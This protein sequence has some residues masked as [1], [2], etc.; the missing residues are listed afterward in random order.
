MIHPLPAWVAGFILLILLGL[1]VPW[2]GRAQQ[3]AGP[4]LSLPIACSPGQD[5]WLVNH[6]DL[7]PA[8]P[9]I[10]DFACGRLTYDGHNG[11]DLAIRDRAVMQAGVNV[12]AA[13]PGRVAGIRDELPDISIRDPNPPNIAGRECGNGL[14]IDHGN[15]WQTQY[16]HMKRG[17]LRVAPGETV[18]TGTLL[19]QVGLS[20]NTEYP[21]LHFTLRS[22]GQVIDPFS[23]LATGAACGQP[24]RPL[25]NRATLAL[26][27]YRGG[28]L[29][30]AGITTRQPTQAGIGNGEFHEASAPAKSL[31]RFWV[32]IFTP[33]AGDRVTLRLLNAAGDTLAQQ[34]GAISGNLAKSL[35][36][37]AFDG[38][39][40]SWPPGQYRA[41]ARL[42]RQ[43]Q[44]IDRLDRA[45]EL[46]P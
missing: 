1:A 28:F 5:C 43:G 44:M 38:T 39:K 31:L 10:S 26:L 19:G 17:S 16:C 32:E 29:Y 8:S 34:S 12:L 7:D 42:E 3:A 46:R 37:G 11:I 23:G 14:V 4:S 20:G 25:W 27:P 21:H 36:I 6:V 18:S 41:E 35:M 22:Q 33:R 24:P 40:N 2:P 13:A 30:N 45:I 15:G 9:G